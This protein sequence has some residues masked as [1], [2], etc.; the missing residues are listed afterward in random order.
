MRSILTVAFAWRREPGLNVME[1]ALDVQPADL[2]ETRKDDQGVVSALREHA[3][4]GGACREGA[5]I[6]LR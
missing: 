1:R 5:D 3:K 4:E 2:A 6:E